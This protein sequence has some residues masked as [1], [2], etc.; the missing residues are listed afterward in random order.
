QYQ[1]GVQLPRSF[2]STA[3]VT[4]ASRDRDSFVF[5]LVV[6]LVT[7]AGARISLGATPEFVHMDG[8]ILLPDLTK[9]TPIL[10]DNTLEELKSRLEHTETG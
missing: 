2:R 9:G 3:A 1:V 6:I 7:Q 8:K 10:K 4:R 5:G